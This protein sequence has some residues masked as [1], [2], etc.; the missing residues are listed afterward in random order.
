MSDKTRVCQHVKK[1]IC[2]TCADPLKK[3]PAEAGRFVSDF[4]KQLIHTC[5]LAGIPT[6]PK[7]RD[8]RKSNSNNTSNG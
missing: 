8:N 5:R 7:G 4:G 2:A 3:A 1:G 6:R